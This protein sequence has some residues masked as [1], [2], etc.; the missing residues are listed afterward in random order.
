MAQSI[1]DDYPGT[2]SGNSI[3]IWN[4]PYYWW[5]SGN[6][7]DTLVDY[8]FLTGDST[9]ND[10]VAQAIQAQIGP[11]ADYMPPN[12]TKS[13]VCEVISLKGHDY[14]PNTNRAT[15]ISNSG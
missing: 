2:K 8:W 10:V 3:G 15:M 5:S 1:I 11:Q 6:I 12:Q 14:I 4:A 7:W 13:E 9:Y